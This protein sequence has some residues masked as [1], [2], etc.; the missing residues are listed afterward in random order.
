MRLRGISS[1][2]FRRNIYQFSE[3]EGG[4]KFFRF[5]KS[6]WSQTFP[7]DEQKVKLKYQKVKQQ[8]RYT[9]E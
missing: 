8:K 4:N 2:L 7:E 1:L 3:E 5:V 9:Q 6:A